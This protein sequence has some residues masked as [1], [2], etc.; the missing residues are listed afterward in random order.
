MILK[1]K[2]DSYIISYSKFHL[3][4]RNNDS[5]FQ[6]RFKYASNRSKRKNLI[7]YTYADLEVQHNNMEEGMLT[8][9]RIKT[10]NPNSLGNL[11]VPIDP[12]KLST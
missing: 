2:N 12:L 4:L 7:N 8:K 1:K 3:N 10:L 11:A 5:A 6:F 9:Q